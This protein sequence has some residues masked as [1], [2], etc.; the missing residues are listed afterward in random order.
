MFARHAL[1]AACALVF[2][3]AVAFSGPNMPVFRSSGTDVALVAEHEGPAGMKI[4]FSTAEGERLVTIGA[5]TADVRLSLPQE[6]VRQEVRGANL[7][8]VRQEEAGLG[9]V[10]WVFPAGSDVHFR[11]TRGWKTLT[12]HNSSPAPLK[13]DFVRIDP[14]SQ[15]STYDAFLVADTPLL[16]DP[17]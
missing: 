10:R 15:E 12:L 1:L 4:T 13:V 16:L 17:R 6:W 8:D 14:L 5:N 9:Y 3:V 11:S 7:S 2:F